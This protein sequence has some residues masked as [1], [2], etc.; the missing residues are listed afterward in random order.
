MRRPR[1]KA[2]RR[3]RDFGAARGGAL[4]VLVALS[5]STTAH[6]DDW[7]GPDKA[8]HATVSAALSLAGHA[9]AIPF[10]ETP[11]ERAVFGVF[12][13]LSLGIGKEFVDGLGLGSASLK[14]LTWNVVGAVAGALLA[15]AVDTW[16]VAPLLEQVAPR[17]GF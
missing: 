13:S 3:P 2:E 9:A 5:C 15:W 6:A 8:L 16:L 1:H 14:D 11:A 7:L 17:V 12:A 10:L 4:A